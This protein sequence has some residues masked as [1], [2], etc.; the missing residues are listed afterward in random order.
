MGYAFELPGYQ[1]SSNFEGRYIL[2]S[3][4]EA[5]GAFAEDYNDNL[6]S[7]WGPRHGDYY[8]GY[9]IL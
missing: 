4:S 1:A 2:F 7:L 8:A 6:E 5:E 3:K 9:E